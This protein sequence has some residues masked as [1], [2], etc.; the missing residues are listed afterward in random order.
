M[1]F[2][3]LAGALTAAVACG[4]ASPAAPTVAGETLYAQGNV[5]PAP[6]A[7]GFTFP[8]GAGMSEQGDWLFIRGRASAEYGSVGIAGKVHLTSAVGSGTRFLCVDGANAI[9]ASEKPCR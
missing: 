3:F 6:S 9:Y 4:S 1:A 8:S 2:A 5:P 7:G